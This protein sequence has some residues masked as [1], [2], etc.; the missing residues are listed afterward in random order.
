MQA[1][2]RFNRSEIEDRFVA[3]ARYLGIEGGF[4]G[5]YDFVGGW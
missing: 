4:D 5:F 3:A 2:M 1:V